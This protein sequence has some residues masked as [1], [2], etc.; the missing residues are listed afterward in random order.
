MLRLR[1]EDEAC[2]SCLSFGEEKVAR[3]LC[4]S[5][6]S[7]PLKLAA[8][9]INT[10][11][12]RRSRWWAIQE[13]ER[14]RV[15][16][17]FSTRGERVVFSL[18]RKSLVTGD[19]S[20]GEEGSTVLNVLLVVCMAADATNNLTSWPYVSLSLAR[21]PRVCLCACMCSVRTPPPS[22]ASSSYLASCHQSPLLLLPPLLL[23]LLAREQKWAEPFNW[24]AIW[25]THPHPLLWESSVSWPA[26]CLIS[27]LSCS[28]SSL[29]RFC[30]PLSLQNAQ[31]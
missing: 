4:L 15:A 8:A 7:P 14:E 31:C 12:K 23:L 1:A 20:R 30:V 6:F 27:L 10:R 19:I 16:R 2:L 21:A 29:C 5:K 18:L 26:S 9:A 24:I 11:G 13:G 3:L 22:Q 17:F 25:P 28:G